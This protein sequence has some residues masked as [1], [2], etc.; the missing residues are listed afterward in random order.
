MAVYILLVVLLNMALR[1][2]GVS[3]FS[4]S[5]IWKPQQLFRVWCHGKNST[6]NT[7]VPELEERPEKQYHSSYYQKEKGKIYDKKPFKFQCQK[8]K[9]YFWC[10]CGHSKR[11]PFC[12]KSHASPYIK[13]NLRPVRFVPEE[14]REY[15]FCNCKQ[16]NNR[17]FCDGSH[18]YHDVQSATATVKS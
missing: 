1:V 11:Q 3:F 12:D 18:K 7:K 15:W 14:T 16:T 6:S 8:G 17:P 13:I 10:S 4:R 2:K 5:R 9:A